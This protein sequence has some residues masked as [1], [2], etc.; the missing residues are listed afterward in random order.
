MC[1][2]EDECYMNSIKISVVIASYNRVNVIEQA[3][4]SVVNQTY[5]NIE[6]II[7]DGGSTDGTVD[8]IKKYDKQISYWV[9]EPDKGLYNAFNK[10][11]MAATGDYIVILGSDDC[12]YERR[13]LEKAVK[14]ISEGIDIL[15]GTKYKVNPNNGI[16]YLRSN[17]FARDKDKYCGGMIPH[18]G[19]FVRR[20]LRQSI[21][22]DE[23]YRMAADQKF[24]LI[25]YYNPKIRFKYIDLPIAYFELSGITTQEHDAADMEDLRLYRELDLMNLI[26]EANK[27]NNEKN[28]KNIVKAIVKHVLKSL[29]IFEPVR[30]FINIH[31]RKTWRRHHCEWE[32]CRWCGR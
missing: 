7:I 9:S 29:G 25:N 15:S 14:E 6:L 1:M 26:N 11:C 27:K 31:I 2:M 28:I 22:F 10:G 5:K 24:F 13:T 18:E 23:T 20:E 3:I 8:I 17:D 32:H 30:D 21:P 12:F 16:E 4:Y 19:M